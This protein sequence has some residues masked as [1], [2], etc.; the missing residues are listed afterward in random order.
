[1]SRK[2]GSKSLMAIKIDLEK[3]YDR[4]EWSFI[5]NVPTNLNF[6]QNLIDLILSCVSLVHNGSRT[7]FFPT[8]RGIRQGD[9]LSPYLF[10]LCLEYLSGQI[11]DEVEIGSWNPIKVGRSGVSLSHVF[12]ADDLFFFSEA[13]MENA[14]TIKRVMTDF[15]SLFGQRVN[16]QK[17]KL[18]FS[19][20]S[21]VE[22]KSNIFGLLNIP[23]TSNLGTYLG[24]PLQ[25]KCKDK[26]SLNFILDKVKAAGWKFTC[27]L[28]QVDKLSSYLSIVLF[29]HITCKL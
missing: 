9:P 29:L 27:F 24:F 15:C 19:N 5:R 18:F 25:R 11:L 28:W 16:M 21:V 6:P 22:S 12:F 4:L 13:S 2:K 1:M 8:S 26:S 17:S 14:S 10:I 20:N 7:E 23:M 3:A